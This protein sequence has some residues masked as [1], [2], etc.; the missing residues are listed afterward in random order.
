[1]SIT[2]FHFWIDTHIFIE[3]LKSKFMSDEK[4]NPEEENEELIIDP[5]EEPPVEPTE[6]G[7]GRPETEGDPVVKDPIK[8]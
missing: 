6:D 3:N 4:V 7:A 2:H 1:M 5:S 8:P